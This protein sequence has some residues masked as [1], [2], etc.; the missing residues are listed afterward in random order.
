MKKTIALLLSFA[1]LLVPAGAFAQEITLPAAKTALLAQFE[2]LSVQNM[3]IT[4]TSDTAFSAS[5]G[6]RVTLHVAGT[7]DKTET[8]AVRLDLSDK[9]GAL[10]EATDFGAVCG[11]MMRMAA[12]ALDL[13]AANAA[14]QLENTDK[15]GVRTYYKDQTLFIYEVAT[16]FARFSAVN[17]PA[18]QT[19]IGLV[20]N[21]AFLQLDVPPLL[22][23][24]RT[25]VP[26]RGIFEQLGAEVKW[27]QQTQTATLTEG[28]T[29]VSVQI[30]NPQGT[31]NGKKIALD[32]PP[33]LINNRTLVP[34]RFIAEALGAQVGWNNV[35]QIVVISAR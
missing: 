17:A 25:L 24:D 5:N 22:S 14:L 18:K 30:G 13:A 34:V 8:M 1:L 26:V 19:G 9:A 23:N 4:A 28:D 2:A 16:A 20:V 29:V 21:D 10:A 6:S 11:A 3:K 35:P 12:P 31:V 32:A 33:Q 15:T 27:D 7:Q